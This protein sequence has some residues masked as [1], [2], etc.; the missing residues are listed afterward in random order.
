LYIHWNS[1][2]VVEKLNEAVPNSSKT[3]HHAA[4]NPKK[5]TLSG[6]LDQYD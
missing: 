2:G 1:E 5:N 3:A 6:S 4:S